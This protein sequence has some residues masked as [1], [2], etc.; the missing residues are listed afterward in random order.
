MLYKADGLDLPLAAWN[1]EMWVFFKGVVEAIAEVGESF[2]VIVKFVQLHSSRERNTESLR[3][4]KYEKV[5]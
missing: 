1:E 2:N 3:H 4:S 5:W